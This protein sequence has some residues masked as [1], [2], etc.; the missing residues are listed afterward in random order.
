MDTGRP[1]V[2]WRAVLLCLFFWNG[3]AV[4]TSQCDD[5]VNRSLRETT[6]RL[7]IENATLKRQ[8]QDQAETVRQLKETL[9]IARTES[10]LFRKQWTEARLLLELAGMTG[11]RTSAAAMIH[12]QLAESV[13]MLY[14]AEAD[15]DRLATQLGRLAQAVEMQQGVEGELAR[16]RQ[17]LAEQQAAVAAPTP[18][19]S[20]EAD[21]K[22]S[23][24][25]SARVVD[26]NRAL[27]VAVLDVGRDHGARVGMPFEVIRNGRV[28]AELRVV[29]V[30]RKISGAMTV[31]VKTTTRLQAGDTA[32]ATAN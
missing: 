6:E 24:L 3:I 20:G 32:R 26:V 7:L 28:V 1:V 29:E 25:A 17:L 10:D 23:S 27:H 18:S 16:T 21:G 11:G 8:A 19:G 31:D 22:S 2:R 5:E 12:R 14:L 15:R 13:R 30:R 9:A 4:T